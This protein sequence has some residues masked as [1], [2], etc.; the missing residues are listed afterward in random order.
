MVK[1]SSNSYRGRR[2]LVALGDLITRWTRSSGFDVFLDLGFDTREPWLA[3][4]G[5][6][7]ADSGTPVRI[8]DG[9]LTIRAIDAVGAT[10]LRYATDAIRLTCNEALGDDIIKGVVVL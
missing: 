7:L 1:E 9:V 3:L 8:R 6:D 4:V 10:R 2:D 5:K